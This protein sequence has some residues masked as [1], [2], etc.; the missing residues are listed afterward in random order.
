MG[1]PLLLLLCAASSSRAAAAPAAAERPWMNR[2]LSVDARVQLLL[3]QMTNAEKQAQTIH[4][5]GGNWTEI[6]AQYGATSLGAF[7][8]GGNGSPDSIVQ[9]NMRQSYMVNSSRLGIPVTFHYETLHSGGGGA[10]IF[11]MPCLQGSTWDQALV[12]TVGRI[13]G[14]EASANGGDRGFSYVENTHTHTKT[15]LR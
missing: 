7:P 15:Y 12:G 8:A 14:L 9:Q 3:K 5:T 13:I 4:L 6:E 11:P 2:Q 1:R 10:T